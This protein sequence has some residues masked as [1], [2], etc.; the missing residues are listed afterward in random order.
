M[1]KVIPILLVILYLAAWLKP[2][3]PYVDY[4]FNKEYFATVLCQNQEKPELKCN[5]KCHLNRQLKKA[6]KEEFDTVQIT[7]SPKTE[8]VEPL[9]T[10]Q[11]ESKAKLSLRKSRKIKKIFIA[12]LFSEISLDI[13]SPPPKIVTI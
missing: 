6:S 13:P 2:Y 8:I 9:F 10:F 7:Y 4:V 12:S 3:Y 1:R 5:G 11:F